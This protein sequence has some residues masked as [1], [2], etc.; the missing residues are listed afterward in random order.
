MAA[1]EV[2]LTE[3]ITFLIR[4]IFMRKSLSERLLSPVNFI[5][6]GHNRKDGCSYGS[7]EM[8]RYDEYPSSNP[9]SPLVLFWYGGSWKYGNRRMYRFV[10]HRLQQLGAH[11]FVIDYPKYPEQSFPGFIEDAEAALHHITSR[12]P[13][14]NILFMGHSAGANTA[15][16]TAM[17]GS[18]PVKGVVSLAGV[19]TLDEDAWLEVF[20]D[21]LKQKK[22]DPRSYVEASPEQTSYL[23]IHGKL[24]R[25][26]V[27][28]D[29]ISLDQKLRNAKRK[30]ELILVP[31]VEHVM[32]LPLVIFGPLF[33]T[34]RRLKHFIHQTM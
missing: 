20:G 5:M 6:S 15:L 14:R 3:F 18:R 16:L 4:K 12:Y 17:R 26:V 1:Y 11:A 34:R 29:S 32:I 23:L 9:N 13:D 10:G 19:C 7:G 24:D 28:S 31:L 33:R 25:I 21:A 22:H 30:S 2:Y 27:P 8:M